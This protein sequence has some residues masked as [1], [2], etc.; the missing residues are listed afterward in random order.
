MGAI[1][2]SSLSPQDSLQ[3]LRALYASRSVGIISDDN[4]QL[5]SAIFAVWSQQ[6]PRLRR[7]F[8][9]RT[10]GFVADSSNSARFDLQ[11]IR[12]PVSSALLLQD[13]ASS[14]P[15]DWETVAIDDLLRPESSDFR[16][17]LWRYGSDLRN[18]RDRYRFLAQLYLA[19]RLPLY[20]DEGFAQTLDAVI[21]ALPQPEDGR[22]LKDD[23]LSC[24]RSLYSL[25]PAADPVAVLSCLV[26]HTDLSALT[27]SLV[28]AFEAVG[29]LWA[30]RP[31]EILAIAERAANE[32]STIADELLHRLSTIVEPQSFLALSGEH[33]IVRE[34][35]IR[36]DPSLLDSPGIASVPPQDLSRLLTLLPDD[37]ELAGRVLNRL[38][39]SDSHDAAALFT[40]RFPTQDRVFDA[41]VSKLAGS[42]ADVPR[43]WSIA[44]RDRTP[45][46]ASRMLDRCR[47]TTALAALSGWLDLDVAAGLNASPSEWAAV[48]V[49]AE[50]DVSGQPKQRLLVYVL[51]LALAHGSQGSEPLFERAFES[52][53]ADIGGG[54]L[55]QDA[56]DA[57]AHVLPKAYWWKEWDMCFRLRLGV[58]AAYVD[59]E[60]DPQSFLRLTTNSVLLASLTDIASDTPRGRD[61]MMRV[62]DHDGEVRR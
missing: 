5:D 15:T 23:L 47:T 59:N 53:H 46:L 30:T 11:V 62:F 56:V 22:L 60:L 32:S 35:I 44:V 58:V 25:L 41:L 10:A 34:R 36:T 16:R 12:E 24:G 37:Q 17:F 51:A 39:F 52:T 14:Q 20:E 31:S 55:P 49:R 33:P 54:R 1:P 45:N 7:A 26:D 50:D 28:P 18:G 6:W 57:L 9:F 27:S 43:A 40:S 2:R 13:D 8:S 48:L 42:G 19:T 38:L 3:V 4:E 29:E 21:G 61:F